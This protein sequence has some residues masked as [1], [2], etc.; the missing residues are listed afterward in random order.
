MHAAR[1]PPLLPTDLDHRLAA[2]EREFLVAA[3]ERSRYNQ[4]MAASLLGLTYHQ[5]R[6][7]LRKHDISGQPPA[8]PE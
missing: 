3:L 4:R 8:G 5:F 2:F 1:R 6:G 7:R